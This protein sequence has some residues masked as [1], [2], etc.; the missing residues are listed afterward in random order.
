[1]EVLLNNLGLP[2][3]VHKYGVSTTATVKGRKSSPLPSP[4]DIS[5][6]SF[7]T[8]N[9]GKS[10]DDALPTLPIS[11]SNVVSSDKEILS[12]GT[13]GKAKEA[14]GQKDSFGVG[15]TDLQDMLIS[16]LME[17]PKGM[18]LKVIT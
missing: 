6:S 9:V 17:N 2:K 4:P 16:L 15:P 3:S 13:N 1:M 14:V 8:G 7:G 10:I 5:A 11:K 12:R 18:S